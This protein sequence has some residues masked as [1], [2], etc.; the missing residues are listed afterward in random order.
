MTAA[1][2]TPALTATADE[3][4]NIT[5]F[6]PAAMLKHY[7]EVAELFEDAKLVDLPLFAKDF[8]SALVNDEEEDG[9]NHLHRAFDTAFERFAEGDLFSDGVEFDD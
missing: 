8:A 5:I 3:A 2:K 9:T 6:L 7:V 4:G 1:A